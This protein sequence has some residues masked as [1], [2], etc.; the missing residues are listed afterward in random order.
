[1]R[2][3]RQ[4]CPR[5]QPRR[6]ERRTCIPEVDLKTHR[7]KEVRRFEVTGPTSDVRRIQVTTVRRPVHRR[8]R[9][10]MKGQ[11]E[12]NAVAHYTA[13]AGACHHCRKARPRPM[14]RAPSRASDG[15][16]SALMG[17]SSVPA[18]CAA[19]LVFSNPSLKEVLFLAQIDSFTQPRERIR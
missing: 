4:N 17:R 1:M 11:H 15:R 13:I 10:V 7:M 19:G 2:H 9:V 12:K 3:N 16:H 8:C 18:Q 14:L 6:P 5:L